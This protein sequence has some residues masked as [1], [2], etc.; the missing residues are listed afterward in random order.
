MDPESL[1]SPCYK[2][3]GEIINQRCRLWGS[4]EVFYFVRSEPFLLVSVVAWRTLGDSAG[5]LRN[6]SALSA[7]ESTEVT[8]SAPPHFEQTAWLRSEVGSM[9]VT[10]GETEHSASTFPQVA[11]SLTILYRKI[12]G[13]LATP[14]LGSIQQKARGGKAFQVLKPQLGRQ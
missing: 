1:I 13:R 2:C 3:G 6:P 4:Q 8:A 7:R 9:E 14:R 11:L 5:C 12:L 10:S